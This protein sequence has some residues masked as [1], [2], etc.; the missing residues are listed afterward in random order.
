MALN[1]P[2]SPSLNQTFNSGNTNWIWDG[3]SWNSFSTNSDW[4]IS[5]TG[6]Y[7]LSNIGIGTTNPQYKL[8]VLGDINF[9]GTFYQNGSQFVAS[10]WTTGTGDN[11]Y[12]L[13]G[14]VGIGTTNPTA[15]LQVNGDVNLNN[16]VI[17]DSGQT[18]YRPN[19]QIQL[20]GG[21]VQTTRN[22]ILF[23]DSAGLIIDGGSE[24]T[25]GV[26]LKGGG[27]PVKVTQGN[28]LVGT[29]S[30]TGTTSQLLQV[31]GGAY[32]SGNVGIGTTN[33]ATKLH[34]VGI[35]SVSGDITLTYGIG[36]SASKIT[37]G[38]QILL[39]SSGNDP[40][41]ASM[42][43][44]SGNPTSNPTSLN[45][46]YIGAW[47]SPTASGTSN[48]SIGSGCGYVLTTGTG[49]VF[50][51]QGAAYFTTGSDNTFIGGQSGGS[52]TSGSNNTILG[53]FNG[54]SGGLDIRTSN[55]NVVIADGSGNIRLYA[56]SS[57]N[58]GIGTTNPTSKLHIVGDALATGVVTATSFSGS[59]S[60]LTGIVTSITAGSGI[61]INQSTGNVTITSTGGG[62]GGETISPFLLMGA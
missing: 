60:N 3:T 31:T 19:G 21:G 13:N 20:I 15:K 42:I 22:N 62:G 29:S 61:S 57:G 30:S 46:V 28:L 9:T 38:S 6:L 37:W 58:V 5:A 49:N 17:T 35:A 43:W 7:T 24:E 59:G 14:N 12:K 18:L 55:N 40:S 48:V 32:V 26:E 16:L 23:T 50:V 51:G 39:R 1:F 45:S 25:G 10:R 33:P 47:A 2:N 36:S 11:I 44:N 53:K 52:V 41:N 8:D 54:N 34:V 4:L 27:G 56:N